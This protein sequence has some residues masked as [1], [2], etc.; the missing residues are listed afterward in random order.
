MIE[1]KD[2]TYSYK[3][4]QALSGTSFSVSS[5]EIFGLLGPNG[6]G[7]TTLFRILSTYL[8]PQSG[9]VKIGKFSL[10][11]KNFKVREKLGVVFQSPSLDT[12]S[13]FMKIFGIRDIFMGSAEQI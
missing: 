3:D 12:S 11:G 5:G 8:K 7:K 2:L 1:I 4:K 9:T 13:P 10:D 6:C